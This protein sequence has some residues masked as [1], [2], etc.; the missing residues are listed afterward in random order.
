MIKW[1]VRV[2]ACAS[3]CAPTGGGDT[4]TPPPISILIPPCQTVVCRRCLVV[5]SMSCVTIIRSFVRPFVPCRRDGATAR[6]PCPAA[7]PTAGSGPSVTASAALVLNR[8]TL[9]RRYRRAR[10]HLS[11]RSQQLSRQPRQRLRSSKWPLHRRAQKAQ[12]PLLRSWNWSPSEAC[13][14]TRRSC[15]RAGRRWA[16]ATRTRS[17]QSTA[18]PRC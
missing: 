13:S 18:W 4:R 15:G 6:R 16:T 17:L 3:A 5:S 11:C 12:S 10:G 9:H 1:C 2:R 8:P 7:R 14:C